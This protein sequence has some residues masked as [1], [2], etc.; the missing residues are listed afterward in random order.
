MSAPT[1]PAPPE[2]KVQIRFQPS[3]WLGLPILF[4]VVVL[5]ILGF[6]GQSG[7]LLT[8]IG[9]GVELTLQHPTRTRYGL[10]EQLVIQVHNTTQ[11]PLDAVEVRMSRRY[12]EQFDQYD[13]LPTPHGIDDQSFIVSIGTIPPQAIRQVTIALTANNAGE[14]WAEISVIGGGVTVGKASFSTWVFP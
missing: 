3:Q 5:A 13:F 4:G 10:H 14:H 8:V 7:R 2:L 11:R 12:I 1:P 6:F 9:D